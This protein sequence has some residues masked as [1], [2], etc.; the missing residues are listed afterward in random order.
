M[1]KIITLILALIALHGYAQTEK[2]SIVVIPDSQLYTQEQG[3]RNVSLFEAQTR[4]IV[5]NYRKENIVYVAHVGDIVNQGEVSEQWDNAV[6]ALS[7]LEQPLPGLPHGIPYGLAVGNHEQTPRHFAITGETKYFNQHFGVDHFKGR[8]YYGGHYG[9]DNDS[10]YDLF[11]A[12]GMDFIVI[13]IEYDAMDENI[14][15]MNDWAASLCKQYSTRKAIIVSH[16]LINNNKVSGTNLKG[17]ASWGKQG[18]KIYD[19]LKTCPNVFMM[20]CGHIGS[21]GEGY[22]QDTYAGK[23][24]KTFLSDYQS[25]PLGGGSLMRLMTFDKDNDLIHVRTIAPYSGTEEKD[26]DSRF[27]RPWFREV[28]ASRIYDFN[29][30]GKSELAMYRNGKWLIEGQ[31]SI[32]FGTINSIPVPGNYYGNGKTYPAVYDTTRC[33]FSIMG[34]DDI[35][36]GMIGD[37]PMPADYDGDGITDIAVWRPSNQTLYIYGQEP[38]RFG[39]LPAFAPGDY[40]GDGKV[41]LAIYKETNYSFH[42]TGLG[43]NIVIGKR[44]DIPVP[45]D[46]NGDGKTDIAVYRP[47][48]GEWIVFGKTP[49]TFGGD[50][51][52][53]PVP[54]DYDGTGKVQFAVYNLKSGILTNQSGKQIKLKGQ[55]DEIVNIPHHTKLY[56]KHLKKQ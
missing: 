7:I 13:Y 4:W 43:K 31:K 51:Y 32:T 24:I 12:A 42:I 52:D 53:I 22:R 36:W 40:D 30:D 6:K 33:V 2:F 48:T 29:N 37:I 18:E 21:N 27:T 17:E 35:Q 14:D 15:A 10:H 56:I 41:E 16:Y 44:G 50:T 46:Y 9:K 5:E 8:K 54:G 25:R 3:K 1:K 11:S 34:Q 20:L 47:S 38:I 28:S 39:E 26:E 55:L 45:A 23:T 49:V 19:R